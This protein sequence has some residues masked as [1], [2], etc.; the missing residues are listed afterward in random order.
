MEE[1]KKISSSWS[2]GKDSA[3]TL[4]L[5]MQDPGFEVVR[6][7]TT[8]GEETKRVECMVFLRSL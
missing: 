5:L 6:L 7:H 8:F 4:W 3:F 2:G 1:K